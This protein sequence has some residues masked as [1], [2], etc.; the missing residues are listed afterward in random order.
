M[1]VKN[2]LLHLLIFIV[3]LKWLQQFWTR[4]HIHIF[5]TMD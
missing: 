4:K 3:T 5:V 2:N 1:R